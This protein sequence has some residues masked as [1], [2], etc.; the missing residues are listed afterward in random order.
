MEVAGTSGKGNEVEEVVKQEFQAAD[1]QINCQPPYNQQ[2]SIPHRRRRG[3]LSK[4]IKQDIL[5]GYYSA[6]LDTYYEATGGLNKYMHLGHC[7]PLDLFH[8]APRIPSRGKT[9]FFFPLGKLTY[10]K[11]KN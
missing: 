2:S 11:G 10:P 1:T 6:D 5:T 4:G 3:L 8:Q 9:G 7:N